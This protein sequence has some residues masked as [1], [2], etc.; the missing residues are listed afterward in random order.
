MNLKDYLQK[1]IDAVEED[2]EDEEEFFD[3]QDVYGGNFD[4]CYNGGF[5]QGQI[6]GSASVALTLLSSIPES[7]LQSIEVKE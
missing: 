4:D 3:P 1:I 2:E 6:D 5:R 7:V